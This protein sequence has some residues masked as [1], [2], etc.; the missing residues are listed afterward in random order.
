MPAG[1]LVFIEFVIAGLLGG[2]VGD[3]AFPPELFSLGVLLP[4]P[5]SNIAANISIAMA[6]AVILVIGFNVH[7]VFIIFFGC[8]DISIYPTAALVVPCYKRISVKRAIAPKQ[9]F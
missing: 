8:V 5:T 2:V 9:A 3:G 7:I 6:N 4:Q 1:L